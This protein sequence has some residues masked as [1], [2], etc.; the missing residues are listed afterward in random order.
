MLVKK[1]YSAL[2]RTELVALSFC[3]YFIL[4]VLI[5]FNH[6]NFQDVKWSAFPRIDILFI[7]ISVLILKITRTRP[8][9]RLGC[10][11]FLLL[12]YFGFTGF[13]PEF[14]IP[15]YKV[16]PKAFEVF[17]VNFRFLFF[18]LFLI[19]LVSAYKVH[20]GRAVEVLKDFRPFIPFFL[21]VFLYPVIPL[22]ISSGNPDKDQLLI[23][24]DTFL[25]FGHN[26][27]IMLE[28]I[29]TPWLT[30]FLTFTYSFYGPFFGLLIGLYFLEDKK[31]ALEELLFMA[32]LALVIGFIFYT[33]VPA[34]GPMY[35]QTFSA[36]LDLKYM[37]EIKIQLMDKPR[38]ARDCFPSLHTAISLITLFS[39]YRHSSKIFKILCP[40]IITIPF[41]CI[42]LRYHYVVDV[43]AGIFLFVM[44]ATFAI[45]NK[46]GPLT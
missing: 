32:T 6:L 4:Q 8:W 13:S 29:V 1:L 15:L 24:I 18:A 25:F 44:I 19:T 45:R 23:Q 28:S 12:T 14:F 9:W 36:P 34:I 33:I 26:P 21:I 38:I 31:E 39:A 37:L 7:F 46:K 27:L 41:A 42:Y 30:E 20:K 35:T 16:V 2:T 43:I 11:S 17:L 5:Q 22:I 40:L 3:L 10:F